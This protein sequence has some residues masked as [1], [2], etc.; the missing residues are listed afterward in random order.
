MGKIKLLDH[1]CQSLYSNYTFTTLID[2]FT[3]LRVWRIRLSKKPTYK[4][5][6]FH[7]INKATKVT[8]IGSGPGCPYGLNLTGW[9]ETIALKRLCLLLCIF[10][11]QNSPN[12]IMLKKNCQVPLH[13]QHVESKIRYCSLRSQQLGQNPFQ[14]TFGDGILPRMSRDFAIFMAKHLAGYY[15]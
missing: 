13:P 7:S 4:I 11:S 12:H 9:S 2:R 8:I 14:I 3:S 10:V 15:L 1:A 6:A 5:R